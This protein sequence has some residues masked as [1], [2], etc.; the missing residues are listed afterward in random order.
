[1]FPDHVLCRMIRVTDKSG[2]N[3][4]AFDEF[5]QLTAFLE[6]MRTNFRRADQDGNGKVRS[7]IPITVNV[8]PLA[9]DMCISGVIL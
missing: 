7:K 3:S 8:L 6:E 4:L 5:L 1:M 9:R 2:K